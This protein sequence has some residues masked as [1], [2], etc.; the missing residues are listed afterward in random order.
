MIFDSAGPHNTEE[1][2]AVAKRA[3]A[4]RGV[5][6]IVV[7]STWGDTGVRA[8][9]LMRGEKAK[10]VVVTHNAGFKEPGAVEIDPGK[11][12]RIEELGGTVHTGTMV[13]RGLG[14]AIRGKGGFSEEMLVAG[15]LRMFGEGVKVCVEM[16]AMVCDAGLV[17]GGDIIA[18][19]GTGRGADTCV[20]VGADSSNR[21]FDI[22][23]RE[24]LAKPG[25]F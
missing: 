3:A 16:A 15:V 20:L 5:G 6:Y 18:V 11:R 1:T 4:E 10:L 2:L 24:I 12:K 23:V 8:A 25:R 17:P 9:E 21:F 13:L 22:K 19:A 14:T 7:A